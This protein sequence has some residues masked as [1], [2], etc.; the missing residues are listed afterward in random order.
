VT[1]SAGADKGGSEDPEEEKGRFFLQLESP[2]SVSSKL[3]ELL[4]PSSQGTS[5]T[6]FLELDI[7]LAKAQ[8]TPDVASAT[9]LQDE[10]GSNTPTSPVDAS[11]K[12]HLDEEGRRTTRTVIPEEPTLS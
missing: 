10:Q 8:T 1:V 9:H 12:Q 11:V 3:Q 4:E 7:E 2:R 6:C 5:S